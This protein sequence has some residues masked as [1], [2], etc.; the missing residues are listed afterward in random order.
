LRQLAA[1]KGVRLSLALPPAA[2]ELRGD[3]LKIAQVLV[4]LVGNAIKF[5]DAGGEV[6]VE[7]ETLPNAYVVHVR[8]QGIGIDESDRARIFESFSQV[9]S[10][11]TRRFGGTGLGLAISKNLYDLADAEMAQLA[12]SSGGKVFPIGDLSEARLAF[13]KVAEEIGTKYSLGYYSSNEKRDGSYRKIK[14]E[15][16]GLPA[17]TQIRAREGYTAPSN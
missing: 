2:T 15:V 12:K 8:D 5:S 9:D 4:N 17:G 13:K 16:K 14:V 7:V 1:S 6:W 3:G 10:G 11:S